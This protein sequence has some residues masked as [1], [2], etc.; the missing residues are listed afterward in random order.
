MTKKLF[1][2]KE[3][4][5]LSS[6]PYV[7]SVSEKGLTYTDE[8]KRIFIEG[9]EKGKLPRVIF[10]ECGFDIDVIGIQRVVSSGNRWR[11]SYKENG[12]FGLRDTRKENSGRKL[13]RELTLEEKYARLEAERNLLKAENELLKK[14]KLMGR[15]D[16]KEI[17]L[18]PSQ[19]Y[20]LIRSV[21]LKYNL[22]NMVSHLC[23]VTGVSRSG[24]YNYFS[25]SSQEQRKQKSDQDEIVKEIILKALRFRNRKKG[26]RQIKMT[27]A[28]HFQVVYN[29]KRIRRIMKKYEIVCP[30]RKANPY[31]RMLKKTKEHRVVPN[32][33]NREFKQN[34]PG[35]T[36]LT[37]ITYLVY[38]KNKRAYLS[39]IL[40]GSTNEILAYHVSEQMTLDLVTTTLHKLKRN[41][42]IRLTEGAYIHSDQGAHY[43]SPTYQKLVKKLKL[44][45][46]MSRRG[47]CWDNAPQES[48][49]GHLKDEA[50]IETRESFT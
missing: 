3:I 29:L 24:Y 5:V 18:P 17:T 31:K 43:T 41:K 38:G 27:L 22:R 33:L 19:K 8:F 12:V 21:I 26:A 42:R 37:D 6:N 20:I 13:E 45:Q 46:S 25:V 36:L 39:T 34:T 50:H 15:E 2:E 30:I 4:Q 47:N 11:A 9:N 48:F 49:F 44:G 1:T 23:K 32:R 28:G 35:K 40:D 14:I 7:K 16:G 10:E